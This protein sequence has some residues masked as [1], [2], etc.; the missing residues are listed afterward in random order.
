MP[1]CSCSPVL[2]G[3]HHGD[4][5][6]GYNASGEAIV[7]QIHPSV[8]DTHIQGHGGVEVSCQK[9][10]KDAKFPGHRRQGGGKEKGQHGRRI[11]Q[12]PLLGQASDKY[13][14][15]DGGNVSQVLSSG[16]EAH[17]SKDTAD[18]GAVQLSAHSQHEA[19]GKNS[20]DAHI[21]HDRGMAMLLQ[22]I[23][24]GDAAAF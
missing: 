3:L 16:A 5:E 24:P 12:R 2:D 4:K 23:R 6:D 1:P 18:G 20:V 13:A 21:Q 8:D 22:I 9:S 7:V 17:N 15:H 10:W 14:Q 19:G 11:G